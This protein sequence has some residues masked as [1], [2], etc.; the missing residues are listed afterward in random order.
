MAA[1]VLRLTSGQRDAVAHDGHLSLQSCPGSGKTRVIVAKMLTCARK[2]AGTP[3]KISCITYTNAAVREIQDRLMLYASD[4]EMD[5]C[6]VSTIHGFCLNSVIRPFASRIPELAGGF[7]VVG[8]D[9]EFFSKAVAMVMRQF[10]LP[11]FLEDSFQSVQ[12]RL[13]GTLF[14][15]KNLHQEAAERFVELTSEPGLLTLSDMVYYAARLVAADGGAARSIGCRFAWILVDEFQDTTD[16]QAAILRNIEKEKRTK[17]FLVGDPNQAIYS[18]AGAKPGLMFALAEEIGAR[19]DIVLSGTHRCSKN[20]VRTVEQL[21]PRVPRM[22]SVGR[23]KD[24]ESKPSRVHVG[25]PS[26]GVLGAFLPEVMRLGIQLGD[27]AILAPQWPVL[28]HLGRELRQKGVAVVGPGARPYRRS[29][30]FAQFAEAMC[31]YLEKQDSRGAVHVQRKLFQML[32]LMT[33]RSVPEVF[34]LDGKKVLMRILHVAA[35][36]REAAGSA[37]A[38]LASVAEGAEEVLAAAA[39]APQEVR[40]KLIDS[41]AAMID[42]I[43]RNVTSG[44]DE[45][46]VEDLAVFARP[47]EC[48]HLLTMHSGK[49]REFDAVALVGFNEGMIPHFSSSTA[50]EYEEARRLA[51]VAMTRAKRLLMVI[52]DQ[53]DTRNRPSRYVQM[54]GL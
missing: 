28:Y 19:T 24:C 39:W 22:E 42:G 54:A 31:A 18:F 40:G 8:P 7:T 15:P 16:L 17:I 47:E 4:D 21:L 1:E 34:S 32:L 33:G 48:V 46:Q 20:I 2:I 12:R 35:A 44:A 50:D 36:Q 51:Y 13:D 10:Q 38:W 14:V 11:R 23:T 41:A 49:G 9:S 45:L 30:E 52:T 43:L 26:V 37:V 5:S 29:L 6:D 3:R 27:T 25:S 53:S